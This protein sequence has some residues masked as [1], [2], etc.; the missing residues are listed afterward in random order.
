M[1]QGTR[2]QP[3][4][5]KR[6]ASYCIVE[7]HHAQD[8]PEFRSSRRRCYSSPGPYNSRYHEKQDREIQMGVR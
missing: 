8:Q 5:L 6:L 7:Q 3:Q 2:Y 4:V 1:L